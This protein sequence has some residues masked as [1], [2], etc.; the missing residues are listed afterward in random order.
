[1]TRPQSAVVTLLN[2]LESRAAEVGQAMAAA[3]LKEVA[4]MAAIDQRDA[5]FRLRFNAFCTQHVRIFV[6]TTRAGRVAAGPDLDFVRDVAAR[7]ADDAFPLSELMEGLRVGYRV[8]NRRITQLGS[9]WDTPAA[10]VLWLT[11]RLID[12]MDAAGAALAEG[13]RARQRRS[14]RLSELARREI[15]DDLV[16]GRFVSRPDAALLA[17]SVG[18]EPDELYCVAVLL[19]PGGEGQPSE[20]LAAEVTRAAV[21][22]TT[23]RFVVPRGDEVVVVLRLAEAAAV[24]AQV[25]NARVG[26]STACRGIGEVARGYWEALRAL[27]FTSEHEPC[28]DLRR[29]GPL[30]YLEFSADAV[31][32]RLSM[33]CAGELADTRLGDTVLAYVDCALNVRTTA[34]R[35]GVHPN[36]VHNRLERVAEILRRP[37]LGPL[38]LVEVATAIRI[39]RLAT[40]AASDKYAEAVI[41]R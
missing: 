28:I 25:K 13:Y 18:F 37:D 6:T 35:M 2:Q 31:A 41:G 10:A 21:A 11:S 8:L 15:L 33:Q 34:D 7:R 19:A 23:F 29:L 4:P 26:L 5:S 20:A 12:Y 38:E 16:E 3:I 39:C 17:G 40:S 30:R 1:V 24:L 14:A 9:G 22:V 27:R 32:R 36:T